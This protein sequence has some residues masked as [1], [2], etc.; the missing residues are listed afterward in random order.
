[1]AIKEL[2]KLLR[3]TFKCNVFRQGSLSEN[4]PYPSRF[5]TYKNTSSDY[6][7]YA[8]D[9]ETA[10][11]Y[12]VNLYFYSNNIEDVFSTIDIARE[13]LKN[14]GW[15]CPTAG[16]DIPADNADFY[17]RMIKIIKEERKI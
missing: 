17:C 15:I 12:E 16:I 13:N 5:F 11:E 3:N 10:L 1:M 6:E 2:V 4:T 14:A 8:D 9:E 7:D